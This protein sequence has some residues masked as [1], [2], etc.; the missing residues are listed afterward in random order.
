MQLFFPILTVEIPSLYSY[1][2]LTHKAV[3][4]SA[5]TDAIE[6]LL[7]E[8][9]PRI[10]PEELKSAHA[11]AYGGSLIQDIGYYSSDSAFF[12]ELT[13][14]VRSGDFVSAMLQDSRN[15]SEYAF[16]LG[17]LA[18]YTAD[19]NGHPLGINRAVPLLYPKLRGRYGDSVTYADDPPSHLNTELAFDVLQAAKGHYDSEAYRDFIGF[20]VS[21]PVL[22]AAFRETYGLEFVDVFSTL[23]RA[24]RSY[25]RTMSVIIPK[26]TE[27]AWDIRKDEIQKDVAG[28]TRDKFLFSYSKKDY[29]KAWGGRY[30]QPGLASHVIAEFIRVVPKVGPLQ[31]L[32]F[33]PPTPETE[34][35]FTDSFNMTLER[36]RALITA[37]RSGRAELEDVNLDLGK[38]TSAGMYKMS[39]DVHAKLVHELAR[40][41]FAG[42]P[43]P[44]HEDVAAFYKDEDAPISTR[45]HRKEWMKL[46]AEL[47]TLKGK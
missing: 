32:Q 37:E 35:L 24:V 2:V 1:S 46:Q 12:T 23:D 10:T 11:Y 29:E 26:I 25:R 28:I 41:Q 30:E 22:R 34:K 39:D 5:W 27:L 13:H 33:R 15:S 47:E 42:M 31:T 16:A 36:Y 8:R 17:A 21:E 20:E 45:K 9:F 44:L 6:P 19:N 4:D 40:R 38:P 3:V 7:R 43:R 14:Y 18:H